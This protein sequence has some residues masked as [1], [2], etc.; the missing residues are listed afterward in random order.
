[1]RSMKVKTMV[2][3]GLALASTTISTAPANESEAR[4]E[5]VYF[6]CSDQAPQ[7]VSNVQGLRA[8]LLDVVLEP[9]EPTAFPGWSTTPPAEGRGIDEG[10][11]SVD[12]VEDA[13]QSEEFETPGSRHHAFDAAFEGTFEGPIAGLDVELWHIAILWATTQKATSPIKAE[14]TIDGDSQT[15]GWDPPTG[16][17]RLDVARRLHTCWPSEYLPDTAREDGKHAVT[18]SL[19]TTGPETFLWIWGTAGWASGLTFNPD[20][21]EAAPCGDGHH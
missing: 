10:C 21:S 11:M 17:A 8:S 14:L 3:G 13:V 4:R 16:D 6:N 5:R 9:D 1:M 19:K 2:I 12:V 7:R 15:W 18:L 20:T